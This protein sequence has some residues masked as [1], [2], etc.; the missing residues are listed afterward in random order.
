MMREHGTYL[1]PT[2]AT[3]TGIAEMKL[4]PQVR[5]K[6]DLALKQQDDMVRRALANG[7]KIA[8][9]TDAG[10]YPHG[11]NAVEFV[12]MVADGMPL[13]QALRAGTSTAADLLGISSKVG[14]LEDGKLADVVAVPGNPLEDIKVTQSV[15]FVMKDGK[16]YRNDRASK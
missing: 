16:I 7:V 12:L 5:V 3:R 9:G 1:V 13:A 15:F 2:L 11:N 4:P 8:L 10:V 6:A 14:T